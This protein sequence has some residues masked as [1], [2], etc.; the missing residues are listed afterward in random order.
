M[1]G[2]FLTKDFRQA[3]SGVSESRKECWW[4]GRI[5]CK[6]VGEESREVGEGAVAAVRTVGRGRPVGREVWA[7][8]PEVSGDVRV[9]RGLSWSVGPPSRERE[10]DLQRRA[11]GSGRSS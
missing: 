2:G 10:L 4:F 9:K 5:D 7:L 3:V 6:G 8:G 1:E 11:R